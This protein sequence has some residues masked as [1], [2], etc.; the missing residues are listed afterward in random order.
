V[1][2][3]SRRAPNAQIGP[4]ADALLVTRQPNVE[5]LEV[6]SPE[7][8]SDEVLESL[9]R[10]V[11]QLH[12]AGISHGRLNAGNVLVVEDEPML[13]DLSAATLGAPQSSLE[14][15][16]AELLVACAVLVGS[17]RALRK[18][19]DAGWADS[20]ARVLPYLQRA[21]LTP[22]LR[23]LA[24]THEVAIKELR[25][26]AAVASGTAEPE[27]APLRRIRARDVLTMAAVVF[28]AYLPRRWP[29]EPSTTFRKRWCKRGCSF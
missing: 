18:A 25:A 19:V 9:W 23:D 15:D 17:D 4:A 10:Q 5:P 29:R 16:V 27:I 7:Q 28:A 3:D 2:S 14:I 8:V 21:A 26:A 1:F 22:H 11:A 24:R 20:V 6:S 12:A 13:V